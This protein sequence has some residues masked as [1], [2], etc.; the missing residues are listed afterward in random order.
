VGSVVEHLRSGYL[1]PQFTPEA[2]QQ[3]LRML[4]DDPHRRQALSRRAS[5]QAAERFQPQQ[6]AAQHLHLYQRL[7]AGGGF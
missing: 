7:V 4:L 2:L 5:Q 3:G 1:L 6:V